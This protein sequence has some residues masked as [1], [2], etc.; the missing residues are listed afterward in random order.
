MTVATRDAF[1]ENTL[2]SGKISNLIDEI[3]SASE[4]QS[5]GIGQVSQAVAEMDR[6]VQQNAAA[7]E[8]SAAASE[9]LNVQAA[10][11]KDMVD[12]LIALVEGQ[13]QGKN[14]GGFSVGD[15]VK[16]LELN[17]SRADGTVARVRS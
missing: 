17:L 12:N 7:A 9:E 3:A 11:M 1:R 2:V 10:Q 15:Q 5:Q 14:L 16:S 8:E 4:E 13:A 6:V